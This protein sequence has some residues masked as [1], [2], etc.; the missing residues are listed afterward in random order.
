M[1]L[2]PNGKALMRANLEAVAARQKVRSVVIGELTPEQLFA[3]NEDRLMDDLPPVIAEVLFVG[4]HVYKSRVIKDSY[5]IED[6]IDEA[7]SALSAESV[8]ISTPYMTAI[9]NPNARADRLGNQVHD[10]AILEC[11]K[12]RPN[13]ELFSTQPKGDFIKPPKKEKGPLSQP[14]S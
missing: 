13:P 7:E 6:I 2:Y 12:Y 1:P 8:M 11:T 9:Q 4:S 5:E 3:I 14:P 10:R